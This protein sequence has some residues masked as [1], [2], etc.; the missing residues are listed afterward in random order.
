MGQI[1]AC[2]FC[3]GTGIASSNQGEELI[4]CEEC[5]EIVC[6]QA[7]MTLEEA[8]RDLRLLRDLNIETVGIWDNG[9]AN[10]ETVRKTRP[11]RL[12]RRPSVT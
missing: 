6:V 1:V 3:A 8:F 5:G 11:R 7:I 9:P 2:P 4:R 10:P 12:I